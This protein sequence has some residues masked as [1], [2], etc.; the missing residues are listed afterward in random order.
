MNALVARIHRLLQLQCGARLGCA[1]NWH[2]VELK[3]CSCMSQSKARFES[4]LD[5]KLCL[6]R[7]GFDLAPYG[8]DPVF[9]LGTTLY[10]ADLDN[11]QDTVQYYNCSLLSY[12]PTYDVSNGVSLGCSESA[13]LQ[14]HAPDGSRSGSCCASSHLLRDGRT[15]CVVPGV[16][17]GIHVLV[18]LHRAGLLVPANSNLLAA[19]PG[20]RVSPVLQVPS[21][22]CWKVHTAAVWFRLPWLHPNIDRHRHALLPHE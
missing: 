14:A 18:V 15:S 11:E 9:K 7:V 19:V 3:H 8:I 13:A 21:V 6:P 17:W 20:Q 1:V 12:K 2:A 10:N 4:R 16:S 22:G 5:C